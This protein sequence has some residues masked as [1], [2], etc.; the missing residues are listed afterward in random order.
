MKFFFLNL[1]RAGPL[2]S[3]TWINGQKNFGVSYLV[4]S[5]RPIQWKEHKTRATTWQY[6]VIKAWSNYL[7][8]DNSVLNGVSPKGTKGMDQYT[9]F[10][11]SLWQIRQR[12]TIICDSFSLM[13][14][15]ASLPHKLCTFNF[16]VELV[17]L[18]ERLSQSHWNLFQMVWI[19]R[20][21][22]KNCVYAHNPE[23]DSKSWFSGQLL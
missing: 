10:R 9:H 13:K 21:E 2:V 17:F 20:A 6:R 11:F 18:K 3:L 4:F 15:Q 1:K 19:M 16:I 14:F 5:Y 22:C 8:M 12:S 23:L 7:K